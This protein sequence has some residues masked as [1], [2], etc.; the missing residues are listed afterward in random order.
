MVIF[1]KLNQ[2]VY[3]LDTPRD[4]HYSKPLFDTWSSIACK[5]E[6]E[7]F[8]IDQDYD[9]LPQCAKAAAARPAP[10]VVAAADAVPA[11]CI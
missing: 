3:P 9:D 4:Y 2:E 6:A 8:S 7:T 10:T 1:L 11:K 5:K